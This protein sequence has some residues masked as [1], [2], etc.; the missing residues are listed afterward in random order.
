MLNVINRL[1]S[2]LHRQIRF[3]SP[4]KEPVEQ[5]VTHDIQGLIK[6]AKTYIEMAQNVTNESRIM[7]TF[8]R[9]IAEDSPDAILVADDQGRIVLVNRR[10]ELLF[11][12]GR[13]E[14]IGQQVEIL[15]PT[16]VRLNH[17]AHRAKYQS[18]PIVREM[19]ERPPLD[20]LR[21]GG[22]EF[23]AHIR[24]GPTVLQEGT[25]FILTFRRID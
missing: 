14:L 23:K 6:V 13:S 4:I 3:G 15:M 18:N 19:G 9:Q 1:L 10:I 2:W 25:Y 17:I 12:Y 5:A 7:I 22:E 11:G 24:I 20:C 21:K 16:A 8:R